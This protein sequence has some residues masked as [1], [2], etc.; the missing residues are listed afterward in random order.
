MDSITQENYE[1]LTKILYHEEGI[2]YKKI[3]WFTGECPNVQYFDLYIED[4]DFCKD[5][6]VNQYSHVED[7]GFA[8]FEELLNC[9]LRTYIGKPL[10]HGL[11]EKGITTKI[12]LSE[13]E[14]MEVPLHLKRTKIKTEKEKDNE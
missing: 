2:R 1:I 6:D 7:P 13:L 5:I 11:V 3:G 4:N 9:A 12:E 14:E 10:R 8:S